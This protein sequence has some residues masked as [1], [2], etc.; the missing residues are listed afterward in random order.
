[1]LGGI[2]KNLFGANNIR[3]VI[4]FI[5]VLLYLCSCKNTDE[6]VL[7]YQDKES[8]FMSVDQEVNELF[9]DTIDYSY[10]SLSG[11]LFVLH[12]ERSENIDESGFEEAIKEGL[13]IGGYIRVYE[14][15]SNIEGSPTLIYENDFTKMNPWAIDLGDFEQD[16]IL[17]IFVPCF[18]GTEF[19]EASRRP[20]VISWDGKQFFK[21]WTGSYIGF[22]SFVS[23]EIKDFTGDGYDELVLK[24]INNEG[25]LE[26]RGYKWGNFTFNRLD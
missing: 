9:N 14:L 8:L 19:Y 7:I 1:M 5:I 21:K 26:E 24:V 10:D 11:H 13:T 20:F 22:D 3:L 16:G 12:S 2:M 4:I 25:E 17:E 23:G 15:S 18:R 6:T